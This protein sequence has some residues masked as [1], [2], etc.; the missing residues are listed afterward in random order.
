VP[1][2]RLD[3]KVAVVTGGANGIGR[4]CCERF[5]QEGA[6]IVIGDIL[7][8]MAALESIAGFGRRGVARH[9]DA[10]SLTDNEA[11]MQTALDQLGGLD[12]VVTAAGISHAAYRSGDAST[13]AEQIASMSPETDLPQQFADL[14]F[15]EWRAVLDVNLT[16]TFLAVQ[17]AARQMLAVGRGGSIITIASIAAKHPDAGPPP[18]GVSKAGVWM[19]TKQAA[20]YLG[21]AGIRVNAIGPGYIHTNMSASLKD[22]PGAIDTIISTLPLRRIGLPM[23]VANAA[24]F[25]ASDESSYFTGEILQPDGGF[26]TD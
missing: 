3:G 26:V 25:L 18:Y 21:P 1:V 22:I 9:L 12:V 6:D 16:G 23:D 24:L 20:R 11:L 15:E 4:A 8:A 5:A 14:P 2:G 17:A 10:R 13:R 19:L 7:D